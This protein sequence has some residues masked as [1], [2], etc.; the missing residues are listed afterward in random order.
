VTKSALV[1]EHNL[2]KMP[3]LKHRPALVATG[4]GVPRKQLAF[5]NCPVFV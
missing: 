3:V 2:S 4:D 5:A 1:V